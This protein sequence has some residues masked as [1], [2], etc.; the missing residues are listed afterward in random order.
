M[1]PSL[2]SSCTLVH[3]AIRQ[4]EVSQSKFKNGFD[5]S[6]KTIQLSL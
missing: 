3:L 2:A 5:A 6:I 4:K 1:P